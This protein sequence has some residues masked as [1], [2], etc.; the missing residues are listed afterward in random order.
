VKKISALSGVAAIALFATG[1]V[2]AKADESNAELAA[3]IRALKM[4]LHHLEAKV[5]KHSVQIHQ[6]QLKATAYQATAGAPYEP[7]QPWDKKFHLAGIT[8]TPGGFIAAEGVYRTR[9]TQGDFSPAFGS[10]PEYNN[11]LSRLNELRGTAR[12]SRFS[13]LVQGNP[14]P[15]TLVSGYGEFDFLGAGVT[16]NSNE[17]NSYQPRVRHLYMTVDWGGASGNGLELLAGQTWS[18]VTMNQKGIT[19]RNEDVPL[20]IDAQYVA[21]FTWARQPQLRL[22]KDF[23]NQFWI[24]ASAEMPQTT[25]CTGSFS[26]GNGG[27]ASA[28]TPITSV[29][30][31]GAVC[32]AVGSTSGSSVLNNTTYYS[33][34]HIP[35]VILKG[36]WEPD[37]LGHAL[38]VEGYGLYTDEYD[39]VENSTS[40]ATIST[41][42]NRYDTTG[43]GAGGGITYS[44]LPH[45]LDLQGSGIV[46][47]GIGR[48]TSG[49]LADAGFNSGNGSLDPLP[50]AS[51]LGGA[52][53][54]ATPQLDLYVYGGEDTILSKTAGGYSS[55][56]ANNTGCY[57]V[58]GTCQGKV[59]DDWE[60]TAGFW[61]KIYQGDFGSVRVGLQYAYI[62]NDLFSGTGAGNGTPTTPSGGTGNNTSTGP[63]APGSQVHFNNQEVYASLRYYPFDPLPPAPPLVTKY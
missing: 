26:F 51:F 56:T 18:L 41:V 16:P 8:I 21:G 20:T 38:H 27:S 22:V 19:P 40:G 15:D 25:S 52:I 32:D 1:S 10:M 58:N 55:L 43:W 24:A 13:L 4:Q 48:Y 11:P 62:Q 35:D 29:S 37:F 9:T 5:D 46:G 31:L 47:R 50:E 44:V 61:D 60:I 36:A 34:N 3:E 54:H 12:Q 45:L 7:P 14:N 17:S 2:A 33:F 39:L 23:G 6:V 63:L 57:V 30:G 59:H 28:N 49:Q 42:N 53:V